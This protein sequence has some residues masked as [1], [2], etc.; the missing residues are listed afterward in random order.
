ML[1]QKL[2]QIKVILGLEVKL[3]ADKLIDGTSIEAE[4]FSPGFP[5]F[6]LA[7]DGT[8]SPAPMGDHETE[9][10]LLLEVDAEGKIISAETKAE[11]TVDVPE[12]EVAVAAAAEDVVPADVTPTEQAN[13]EAAV[14]EALSKMVMAVEQI[15]T[16]VA[17]I[18]KDVTETKAEMASMKSKYEKFSKEPGAAKAPTVTR[19][20]FEAMSAL[21]AKVAALQALKNDNF[22]T[23]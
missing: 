2:N 9:S 19:G 1:K 23:K 12:A 18:K 15:A 10:G 16:D 14:T 7:A 8:K 4:E 20:E 5:L 21:D 17:N 13:K 22:F 11:E 6:I 3:A